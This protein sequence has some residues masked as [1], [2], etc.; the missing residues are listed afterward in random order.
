[1]GEGVGGRFWEDLEVLGGFLV[2]VLVW[3][4]EGREEFF[5]ESQKGKGN[6]LSL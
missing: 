6:V 2:L 3:G 4:L 1:V 5:S